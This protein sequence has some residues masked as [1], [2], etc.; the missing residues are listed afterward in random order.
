MRMIIFALLL[1]ISYAQTDRRIPEFKYG[2][3]T[4]FLEHCP[5]QMTACALDKECRPALECA[6][7]CEFTDPSCGFECLIA[8]GQTSKK[9]GD[10]L[11]CSV[12]HSCIPS[13]KPDKCHM[14]MKTDGLTNLTRPSDF[15]GSWWVVRGLNKIYD[16][17]P[18]QHNDYKFRADGAVVINNVSWTD[19]YG[20]KAPFYVDITPNITV[21]YPG[22]AELVYPN[23]LWIDHHEYWAAVSFP[24]PSW[25][26]MIWCGGNSVANGIAGAIVLSTHKNMDAIPMSINNTFRDVAKSHGIDYDNEMF[27]MNNDACLN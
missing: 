17:Y 26:F 23:D 19:T 3:V 21:P 10:F 9:Y 2:D 4:C 11:K 8:Y 6:S 14:D 13:F 15:I 25:L 27:P 1:A 20:K 7:K 24:D 16:H 22:V 18:C 5:G 12:Q